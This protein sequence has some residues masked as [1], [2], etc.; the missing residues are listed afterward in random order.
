[1]PQRRSTRASGKTTYAGA[2]SRADITGRRGGDLTVRVRR[3]DNLCEL[4]SQP[5]R[6]HGVGYATMILSVLPFLTD[7]AG[8]FPF[9]THPVRARIHRRDLGKY[10]THRPLGGSPHP[11][12]C[13]LRIESN[14]F[15]SVSLITPWA[16]VWHSAVADLW[17]LVP[18]P[19]STSTAH[20]FGVRNET[21]PPPQ[22]GRAVATGP[23]HGDGG[24][25]QHRVGRRVRPGLEPGAVRELQARYAD[26]ELVLAQRVRADPG[27]Q[28]PGERGPR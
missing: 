17:P 4:I 21:T 2:G 28:Q 26:V 9:L 16:P 7:P 6:C 14:F 22:L 25:G 12:V 15:S 5:A 13:P 19:C 10:T 27:V 20:P 23:A 18:N 24:A 3:T 1:M 8:C 11:T